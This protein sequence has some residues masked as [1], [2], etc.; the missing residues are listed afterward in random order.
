MAT[1]V[2]RKFIDHPSAWTNKSVGGKEGLTHHLTER[3]LDAIDDLLKRTRHKKPQEVTRAEFDHPDLTPMIMKL[4]HE[5]LEGTGAIIVKGVTPERYSEEDFERIYWGF[6]LHW[7]NAVVQSALGDRLGHVRYVPDQKVVRAYRNNNEGGLHTDVQEIVGMMSVQ[8]AAVGGAS[9]LASSI[10]I[11]NEIFLNRP[12]LLDPLYRGFNRWIFEKTV[13]TD[14]TVPI[15]S[16]VDGKITCSF[17]GIE[18]A[19]P[20]L[21]IPLPSDLEEAMTY[22]R[23]TSEREDIRVKFIVEP[24]EM[25]VVNNYTC[26]HGRNGFTNG[27]GQERHLLRLWLDLT[28]GRPVLPVYVDFAGE[29]SGG[30]KMMAPEGSEA[31]KAIAEAY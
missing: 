13:A 18:Q 17:F 12:E 15:F 9:R 4:R 8:K 10:A 20:A 1:E 30:G 25:M 3:H 27:P 29:Y 26:L 7:G 31:A 23:D 11:H 19:A 22:F 16:C 5:I 21:G 14:Y 6:G 2:Y 28:D 24:G